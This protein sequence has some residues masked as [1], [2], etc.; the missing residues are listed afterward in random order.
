VGVNT[1]GTEITGLPPHPLFPR[2][3]GRGHMPSEHIKGRTLWLRPS[4]GG[5]GIGS[6]MASQ[7]SGPVSEAT[8]VLD[9]IMSAL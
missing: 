4:P 5:E 2:E 3:G 8:A 6:D 1:G 7:K 9:S